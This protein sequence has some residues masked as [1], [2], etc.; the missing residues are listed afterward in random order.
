MA[1][2]NNSVMKLT[3]TTNMSKK[4][5]ICQNN[6]KLFG[7]FF[8][9]GFGEVIQRSFGIWH[10]KCFPKETPPN[11]EELEDLCKKLGFKASTKAIGRITNLKIDNNE[12]DSKMHR[13]STA[14]ETPVEFQMFNATKV[15]THTKF[16]AVKINDAFTI[17]LRSSKPLAKLVS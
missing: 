15:V 9:N 2:M 11:L 3:S 8:S 17:H 16:A 7:S 12:V 13:N 5:Q 4:M 14:E 1:Q 6:L 10:T